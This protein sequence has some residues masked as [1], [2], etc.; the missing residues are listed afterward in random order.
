MHAL[1]SSRPRIR[2]LAALAISLGL[3]VTLSACIETDTGLTLADTKSPVQLMRNEA[4]SRVPAGLVEEVATASDGSVNC[5]TPEVDPEGLSRS[6]KSSAR[7]VLTPDADLDLVLSK[8]YVSFREDGWEQ[9][10]FGSDTI[11]EFTKEGNIA[12]VR[13]TAREATDEKPAEVQ[14]QVQ[15]PCVMTDGE[16]SDEVTKLG[17]TASAEVE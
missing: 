12:S 11:V 6:W 14:V 15:G 16:T 7:I 2:S 5:R 9:G 1:P 17:S 3:A 13:V 4:A 10:T 8:F